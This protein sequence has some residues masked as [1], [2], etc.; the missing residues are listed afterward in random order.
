[1]GRN[2]IPKPTDARKK[3]KYA[4]PNSAAI[5]SY[6]GDVEAESFLISFEYY[7]DKLCEISLLVKNNAKRFIKDIRTLGNCTQQTLGSSNIMQKKIDNSGSYSKLFKT[8]PTDVDKLYEHKG[9]A[10]SR[11]IYFIAGRV[12]YITTI[13]QNHLEI[14]KRRR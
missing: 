13:L 5:S 1:M 7:D 3:H 9:N 4:I 10:T 12:L 11:L 6:K 8:L 14:N 2:T